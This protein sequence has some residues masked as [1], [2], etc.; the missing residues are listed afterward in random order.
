MKYRNLFKEDDKY[1]IVWF[2]CKAAPIDGKAQFYDNH[3]NYSQYQEGIKNSLIQRLSI[4]KG[5]LWY[6]INYGLPLL[7]KI[8]NKAVIDAAILNI[9]NRHEEIKTIRKYVSSVSDHVYTFEFIAE[10]IYNTSFSFSSSYL[11]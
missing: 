5:E 6:N 3:E 11:Y 7:D 10:T 8:R 4:I 1:N 2:G 9:I